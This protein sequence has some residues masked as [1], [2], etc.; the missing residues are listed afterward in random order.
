M[1]GAAGRARRCPPR[2]RWRSSARPAT[3]ATSGSPRSPTATSRTPIARL[4]LFATARLAVFERLAGS[5]DP[6]LAAVAAKGVKELTYHR[7]YAGRWF[8][9]LA[10]GT[11]ESRRRLL[12]GARPAL[13]AVRRAARRP[14]GRGRG[15]PRPASGVDPATVADEVDVVL[16]QVLRRER[17]RPP[18]ARRRS[19][20]VS[21]RTGRDGLHTEALSRLLAEM[22][23]V[24]RAHPEGRGDDDDRAYDGGS[25]PSPTPRC[26]C[27]P[28]RTSACCATS[29][30]ATA[31]SSWRSPRPTPAARRWPPCATTSCTGC[32]DAGYAD[33]RVRVE[34]SPAWSSDWITDDGRAQLAEHGI[35]PPGAAPAAGRPG[36]RS[37]CCPP[38]A[39]SPA[40]A[41]A[42]PSVELDLG[43]RRD[44]RARRSTAA[45]LP[46]AVRAREGDLMT[47]TTERAPDARPR[48]RRSSTPSPSPT[49]S[50]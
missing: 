31:G 19:A 30:S 18:R 32:T 9:T 16:E 10:Q 50:G 4:L 36:R 28:S 5:R 17:R 29:R 8:L 33:V 35:S 42:R 3:S 39:R 48:R 25:R 40:R 11:E 13:A 21:G 41:A 44:R 22:Q 46:R 1:P 6:V 27:S 7:D 49:S 20:G 23:V 26:R 12:A 43:V 34:L 47:S 15:S 2:T 37:T 38:G 24:A 14:P 45:G